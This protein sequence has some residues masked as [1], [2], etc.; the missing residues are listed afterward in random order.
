MWTK[1]KTRCSSCERSREQEIVEE[2]VKEINLFMGMYV[3]VCVDACVCIWKT[4]AIK[5]VTTNIPSHFSLQFIECKEMCAKRRS[6]HNVRYLCYPGGPNQ[7][8]NEKKVKKKICKETFRVE[9]VC[10]N[11][12]KQETVWPFLERWQL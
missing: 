4:F 12:Q 5:C 9:N 1:P 11:C 10:E 6:S 2:A 8:E 3:C 7:K